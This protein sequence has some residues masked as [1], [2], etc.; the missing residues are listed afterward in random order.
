MYFYHKRD[1]FGNQEGKAAKVKR[2]NGKCQEE[3]PKKPLHIFVKRGTI[4]VA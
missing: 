4:A 3:K 2:K 1:R